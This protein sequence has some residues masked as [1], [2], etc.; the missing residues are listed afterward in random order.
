MRLPEPWVPED[1]FYMGFGIPAGAYKRTGI[2]FQTLA[3]LVRIP[4]CAYKRAGILFLSLT[5]FM[6][7]PAGRVLPAGIFF[8]GLRF[9]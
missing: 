5:G 1:V 7:I 6:G 2:L 8:Y 4:T 3:G 9:I